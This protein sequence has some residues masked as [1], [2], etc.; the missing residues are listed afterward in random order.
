MK[1]NL[2]QIGLVGSTPLPLV[3]LCIERTTS[4]LSLPF[5]RGRITAEANPG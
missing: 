2:K 5:I 3:V 4:C 1:R